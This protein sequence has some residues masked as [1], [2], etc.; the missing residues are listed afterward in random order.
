MSNLRW[1]PPLLVDEQAL[2]FSIRGLP[3]FGKIRYFVRTDSTQL[4][5]L[6]ALHRLDS[7]GISFVTESQDMG[8][9]RAG[10]RWLSPTAAGLLVST[11]LPAQLRG[12]SLAAVGFWAALAVRHAVTNVCGVTPALKWP[13]DLLYDKKKLAGMLC[14]GRTSGDSSRVVLGVGLNVNRPKDVPEEIDARAVWLSD[15]TGS[16][17]DRT[18][19]LAAILGAYELRFDDLLESAPQVIAEWSAAA[20]VIGKRVAVRA[21]DG[22]T[23][24]EG[25]VLGLS[26]E[27]ALLLRT[28]EGDVTVTLGDVDVLS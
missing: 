19:L 28:S 18:A 23:K 13:N 1:Y 11:I 22:A 5:A 16:L 4:R 20:G 12:T 21:A 25:L 6:E 10:R 26:T 8:R 24:H 7:Q 3:R 27:G 14:E 17:V 15:A 2:S 9:G